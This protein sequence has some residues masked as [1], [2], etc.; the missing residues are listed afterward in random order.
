MDQTKPL[1]LKVGFPMSRQAA[2]PIAQTCSFD[3][4]E[5]LVC[6]SRSSIRNI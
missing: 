2:E 1:F 5:Y 6:L 3:I 4:K